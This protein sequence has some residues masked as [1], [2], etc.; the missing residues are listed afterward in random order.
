MILKTTTLIGAAVALL[1]ATSCNDSHSH[2][3][4]GHSHEEEGHSHDDGSHHHHENESDGAASEDEHEEVSLGSHDIG[5]IT[6]E[7]AQGHGMA[8][9]GKEIHLVVKLPYNDSGES[10][11]RAWVGS[12]DRTLSTVGKAEFTKSSGD[13][14]VHAVAPDPLAD[15]AKWW[16]EIEKPDGS[17]ALGSIPLLVGE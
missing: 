2:S 13:Y 14:D 4:H 8:E 9:A 11:V 16:V 6:V 12:E 7:A 3:D 17:K 1:L 5:G 15:D 10:V